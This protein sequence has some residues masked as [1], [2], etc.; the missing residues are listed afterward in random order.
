LLNRCGKTTWP[1]RLTGT[2]ERH[3]A[4]TSTIVQGI[5]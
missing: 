5:F 2:A 3:Q 1:F 4:G